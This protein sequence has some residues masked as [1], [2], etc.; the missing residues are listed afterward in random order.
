MSSRQRLKIYYRCLI[1]SAVLLMLGGAMVLSSSAPYALQTTGDAFYYFKRHCLFFVLG[2]MLFFYFRNLHY[3]KLRKAAKPLIIVSLVLLVLVLFLGTE[4]KGAKRAIS[5]GGFRFQPS[6]LAKFALIVY[7]ANFFARYEQQKKSKK[8]F[9]I[10]ACVTGLMMVLLLKEPD[11][12]STVTVFAYA[13][14]FMIVGGISW[15]IVAGTLFS[16]APAVWYLIHNKPYMWKRIAS[17]LSPEKDPLGIG[18]HVIQALITIGSGGLWGVGLGRGRQKL[19]FLPEAHKDYVFA[20]IGEELGFVGCI[21]VIALFG[22][23]IFTGFWLSRRIKDAFGRYLAFGISIY[24][25][26][27]V[28]LHAGVTMKVLPP[29]GTTLPFF[30]YGGSSLVIAMTML[31]IF[32]SLIRNAELES[33][34]PEMISEIL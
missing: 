25:G 7:L 33:E 26:I 32:F 19:E 2:L 1:V 24:F 3:E 12:G 8:S 16:F 29:K 15:M 9:I 17:F 14:A 31:G 22:T 11:F 5:F 21:A 34:G 6:E 28:F 18:Y 23:L 20:V 10:P 30:S 13:M 27:Q 4:I